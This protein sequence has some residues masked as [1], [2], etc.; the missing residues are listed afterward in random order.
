MRCAAH[1]VI[2]SI[3]TNASAGGRTDCTTERRTSCRTGRVPPGGGSLM[4]V[5]KR[6]RKQCE[7]HDC[8]RVFCRIG[9]D[10]RNVIHRGW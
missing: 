10:S 1:A 5:P 8:R 6:K 9:D 7:T 4:A 3:S 2:S